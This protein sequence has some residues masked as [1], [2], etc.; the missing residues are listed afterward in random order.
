MARIQAAALWEGVEAFRD[1]DNSV[2]V[3]EMILRHEVRLLS[4]REW[5]KSVGYLPYF[6]W[7]GE[8]CTSFMHD[9]SLKNTDP[10]IR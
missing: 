5:E 1:E 9:R 10:H 6:L 8:G 3:F 2:K 4:W 7:G